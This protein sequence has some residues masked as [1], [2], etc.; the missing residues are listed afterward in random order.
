MSAHLSIL[1]KAG[2]IE[3]AKSG[4]S[5]VYRLR[6]GTLDGLADYIVSVSRILD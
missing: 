5:V 1:S 3:G 2:L 4:R 6:K